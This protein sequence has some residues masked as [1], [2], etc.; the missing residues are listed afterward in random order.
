M[1]DA[2]D[3]DACLRAVLGLIDS[4]MTP[5]VE[6]MNRVKNSQETDIERFANNAYQ[7]DHLRRSLD[8]YYDA[9]M[10]KYVGI[11]DDN[12]VAV[13]AKRLNMLSYNHAPAHPHFVTPKDGDWHALSQFSDYLVCFVHENV[14]HVATVR[15]N[16]DKTRVAFGSRASEERVL[17]AG[18]YKWI[19]YNWQTT[20][21]PGIKTYIV[22]FSSVC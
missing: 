9:I 8:M 22:M 12:P 17:S 18:A 10:P 14:K 11:S 4:F 7:L 21:D 3:S 16:K 20:L 19:G 6:H 1:I 5:V 15:C 2:R 13:A